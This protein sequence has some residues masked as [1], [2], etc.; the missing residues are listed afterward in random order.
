MMDTTNISETAQR[1]VPN[2]AECDDAERQKSGTRTPDSECNNSA[3]ER[4]LHFSCYARF[5]PDIENTM[6]QDA[7]PEYDPL[8][9]ITCKCEVC[10]WIDD[11]TAESLNM[12]QCAYG[13]C[14]D[15]D[16][17]RIFILN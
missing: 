5:T 4:C 17:E 14:E 9:P 2:A 13:F 15:C 6:S 10:G 8:K 3:L 12:E 11:F 7:E 1:P 16:Q